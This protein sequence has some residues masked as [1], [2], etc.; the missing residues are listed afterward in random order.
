MR[1]WINIPEGGLKVKGMHW[2]AGPRELHDAVW[3]NVLVA[4]GATKITHEQYEAATVSAALDAPAKKRRAAAA[5]EVTAEP[6]ERITPS[7]TRTKRTA[8]QKAADKPL[9][10]EWLTTGKENG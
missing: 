8:A 6:S 3:I 5:K 10:D 7:K 4:A 1:G 2:P 9:T